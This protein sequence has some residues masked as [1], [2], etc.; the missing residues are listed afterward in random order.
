M[1][2]LTLLSRM[3]QVI[4][5]IRNDFMNTILNRYPGEKTL[6]M[7]ILNVTPDSF[8]DGGLYF[9]DVAKA[10]ARVEQMIEEGADIID[11]GGESTRPGSN[12]ISPEEELKRIIPI[13]DAVSS[14]LGDKV[15]LSVDTYKSS[16]AK[17]VLQAGAKMINSLGGFTFDNTLADV[18]A[19]FDCPIVIY[20]I[21]GEPQTMLA[22]PI[23]YNDIIDEIV[24]F[25]QKELYFG[26]SRSMK[27]EQFI[28]DPG[29][30]FGKTLEHNVE[31]IK[32]LQEFKK[33]NLPL[34]V[35]VS[36]K[37]HLGK[38]LQQ[39]LG[40]T[41]MPGVSER[42]EASLAE[43]A[44]AVLKGASIVRTHDVLPTVKFLTVLDALKNDE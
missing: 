4:I 15:M 3:M 22:G 33:L 36:R 31:I 1:P 38:L 37:G 20:H 39:R 30:G 10:V 24:V 42:L 21:K 26:L 5:V 43:T 16:V 17:E 27:R 32:R 25:F 12:T 9:D 14:K 28:L 7:G 13:I 41:Q 35:G 34:L 2:L 8:S 40:L 44:V 19:A 29:I 6:I 23:V 11:I 18:V